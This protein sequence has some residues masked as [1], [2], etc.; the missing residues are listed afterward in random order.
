MRARFASVKR[1]WVPVALFAL[2]L[3]VFESSPVKGVGDLFWSLPSAVSLLRE[4]NVDLDEYAPS[5]HVDPTPITRRGHAQNFFPPGSTWLAVVPLAVTDATVRA[6]TPLARS[7]HLA[8]LERQLGNWRRDFD[9]TGTIDPSF[10]FTVEMVLASLFMAVAT[11]FTYAAAR[12]RGLERGW[13]ALLALVFAFATPVWSTASR[14]LGQH[15]PS[16][17][18]VSVALWL[19]ARGQRVPSSVGWAGLFVG[20]SY[21]MRPTNS[22]TVLGFTVF[23]AWA[24]RRQLPKFLGLG[25]L[26]AVV[27]VAYSVFVYDSVLPP[28]YRPERVLP[29]GA[30]LFFEAL[31]GNLVSPA[32]GLLVFSPVLAFA[33]WG[34][35][36]SRGGPEWKLGVVL[37]ALVVG[38]WL[39]VSSFPHWWA[40]HS[41]GPRYMTDVVPHL[42]ALLVPVLLRLQTLRR[43]GGRW[44]PLAVTMAVLALFSVAVHARGATS[45]EPARWN[46]DPVN[47]DGHPQRL[48]DF[49]DPQFLR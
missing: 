28:Y 49:S 48:W 8:G 14:D 2:V 3:T 30:A 36:L 4:G 6:L 37:A 45:P 16:V 44:R 17:L 24:H 1:A 10:F 29:K 47:V 42:C 39:V 20:L 43:E 41:F 32:R 9:A 21:V 5:F 11:L 31:A 33:A 46:V 12:E 25:L 22:L 35:W 13:A 23:V 15:G 40:G 18:M 34:V 7:L 27:F 26:V 38:H 19:V